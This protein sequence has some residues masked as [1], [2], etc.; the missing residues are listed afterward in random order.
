MA[1]GKLSYNLHQNCF[2][3]ED[4]LQ[5]QLLDEST[6]GG[7]PLDLLLVKRQELVGDM[8]AKGHS[9]HRNNE[10]IV[11]KLWGHK[12]LCSA[13]GASLEGKHCGAGVCL[14]KGNKAVEESG[15]QV[16]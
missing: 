4:N 12:E 2:R 15:A 6:R 5:T 9:G 8:M 11:F 16:L 13:L 3:K 10:N 14:K 7:A 1:E